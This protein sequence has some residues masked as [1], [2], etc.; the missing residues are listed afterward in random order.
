MAVVWICGSTSRDLGVKNFG[1]EWGIRKAY[2]EKVSCTGYI[3][4]IHSNSKQGNNAM[5]LTVFKEDLSSL[6]SEISNQLHFTYVYHCSLLLLD[7]AHT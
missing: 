4:W 1:I 5:S 2:L 7:E 6:E 3:D